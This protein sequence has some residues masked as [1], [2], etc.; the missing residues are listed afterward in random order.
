[1]AELNTA[2]K[3]VTLRLVKKYVIFDSQWISHW[4][5][6]PNARNQKQTMKMM[7]MREKRPEKRRENRRERRR[8]EW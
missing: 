6:S 8:I 7:E 5:K 4:C 3:I 2:C 1:M